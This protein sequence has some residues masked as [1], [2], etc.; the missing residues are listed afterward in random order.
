LF[1]EYRED[2][3]LTHGDDAPCIQ[4]RRLVSGLPP[5]I[6]WKRSFVILQVGLDET[7]YGQ[8]GADEAFIFAGYIGPVTHIEAF[9]HVWD[10]LMNLPPPLSVHELKKRVRWLRKIDPRVLALAHVIH[11]AHLHGVRFKVRPNDYQEMTDLLRPIQ[12]KIPERMHMSKN[13]Y[14]LAFLGIFLH[15]VGMIWND[16]D[17]KVEVIYDEN[18]QERKRL[19]EGYRQFRFFCEIA[20]PKFLTKIA[21][22]PLPRNDEEFSLLQAADALA[23]HSH[24]A[25]VEGAHRRDYT[26]GLW[27]VLNSVPFFV[28]TDWTGDDLRDVANDVLKGLRR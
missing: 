20:A 22:E 9:T 2:E 23:W 12:M 8:T 3:H 4:I 5:K 18:L 15:L 17:T 26:N 24:R 1:P 16:P 25:H 11:G 19:E 13:P 27:S 7:G 14:F 6:R 28:D 21:K 10:R